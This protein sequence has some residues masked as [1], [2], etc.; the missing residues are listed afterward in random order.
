MWATMKRSFAIA[1]IGISLLALLAACGGEEDAPS[2]STLETRRPHTTNATGIIGTEWPSLLA[3]QSNRDGNSEIY[4]MN[5]AGS[6]LINLTSHPA[7]DFF[8]SWSPDGKKLVF[9]SERDGNRE[10]YMMSSDGSNQTRLTNNNSADQWPAWSPD[11]RKIAF[12][13]MRDGNEEIYVMSP[14]GSNPTNLTNHPADETYP[15]WS[16]GILRELP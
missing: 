9:V 15:D 3:F 10:I 4:V 11:G 14:Y 6:R 8:A 16:P 7:S 5:A 2:P 13:S 1:A 12:T